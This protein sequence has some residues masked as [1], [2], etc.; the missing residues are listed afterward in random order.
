MRKGEKQTQRFGGK[1]RRKGRER[2]EEQRRT[3][4]A[5]L[6]SWLEPAGGAGAPRGPWRCR[7][8]PAPGTP[9]TPG[10]EDPARG[11]GAVSAPISSGRLPHSPWKQSRNSSR[12]PVPFTCMMDTGKLWE[13]E[14]NTAGAKE[15]SF[16][17]RNSVKA[18][19][20]RSLR[21]QK[22]PEVA[23]EPELRAGGALGPTLQRVLLHV[24]FVEFIGSDEDTVVGEVDTAAGLRGLD[25][26]RRGREEDV[27]AD[28][29]W[30]LLSSGI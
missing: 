19:K 5:A 4:Q 25:L 30:P 2:S 15:W 26:L 3:E 7:T 14:A 6:G 18:G 11:C 21:T 17:S 1:R 28:S 13:E 9:A 24:N 27:S 16:L 10:P 29:G 8:G 20:R 12:C 23:A 22:E